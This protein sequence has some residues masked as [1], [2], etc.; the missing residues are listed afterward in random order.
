MISKIEFTNEDI[1]YILDSMNKLRSG[2]LSLEQINFTKI[3]LT[4][5]SKEEDTIAAYEELGNPE[6]SFH[7][8]IIIGARC[9]RELSKGMSIEEK[10][11]I[12]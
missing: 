3:I 10:R 12:N 5:I 9:V 8:F 7:T 6:I 2:I 4:R 1:A 11:S